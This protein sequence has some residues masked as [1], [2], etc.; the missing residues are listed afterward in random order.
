MFFLRKSKNT[1]DQQIENLGFS[2]ELN[3][4]ELNERDLDFRVNESCY[5]KKYITIPDIQRETYH[6][7]GIQKWCFWKIQRIVVMSPVY[8]NV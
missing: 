8:S 3:F 6:L 1:L 4:N 2:K 5:S 7:I